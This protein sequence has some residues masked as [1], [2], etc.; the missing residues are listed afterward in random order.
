MIADRQKRKS[1][2][3][4]QL[5]R[6]GRLPGRPGVARI[7]PEAHDGGLDPSSGFDLRRAYPSEG[8]WNTWWAMTSL[9]KS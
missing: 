4:R 9:P 6:E 5:I 2:I 8:C 3:Y 7:V 1:E